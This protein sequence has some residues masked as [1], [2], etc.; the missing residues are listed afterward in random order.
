M[1]PDDLTRLRFVTDPQLAPDGR[2]I[3]LV[4]SST[5]SPAISERQARGLARP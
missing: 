3:G 4:T 2:R 1:V 5:G